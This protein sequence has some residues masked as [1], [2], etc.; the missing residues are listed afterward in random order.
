M[1]PKNLPQR[2]LPDAATLESRMD[3]MRLTASYSAAALSNVQVHAW[4]PLC[5]TCI[6]TP[7]PHLWALRLA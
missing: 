1:L 7:L 5:D 2:R 6:I 3:C 4:P